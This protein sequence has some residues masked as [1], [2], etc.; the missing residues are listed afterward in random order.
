MSQLYELSIHQLH[1]LLLSKKVSAV[2]VAQAYL[3]RIEGQD[4]GIGAYLRITPEQALHQAEE[5]DKLIAQGD[6]ISVLT[7]IPLAIK[8]NMCTKGIQSPMFSTTMT[9]RP[10]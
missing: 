2:E 10:A 7:G 5:A 1:S 6:G 9:S 4:S 3:Q 8:D